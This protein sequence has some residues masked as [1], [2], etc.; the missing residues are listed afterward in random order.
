[1]DDQ[2]LRLIRFADTPQEAFQILKSDLSR[3]REL[4]SALRHPF[5]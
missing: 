3:D 4:R 1:V 2:D 5:D